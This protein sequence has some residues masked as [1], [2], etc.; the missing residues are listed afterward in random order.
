MVVFLMIF[1]PFPF[2]LIIIIHARFIQQ[3]NLDRLETI[4]YAHNV[5]F[6]CPPFRFYIVFEVS[7]EFSSNYYK[8]AIIK[9]L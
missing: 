6:A 3:V 2:M 4:S 8:R 1:R 7:Q 9:V 5:L